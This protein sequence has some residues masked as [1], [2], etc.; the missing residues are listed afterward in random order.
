MRNA[1]SLSRLIGI[2]SGPPLDKLLRSQFQKWHPLSLSRWDV[3]DVLQFDVGGAKPKGKGPHVLVW[4]RCQHLRRADLDFTTLAGL[5]GFHYYRRSSMR[6]ALSA[7]IRANP[8]HLG[9]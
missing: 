7:M 8:K 5:F 9:S 4:V 3:A 6:L 2:L 1:L